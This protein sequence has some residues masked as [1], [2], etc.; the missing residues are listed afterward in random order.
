MK[1]LF[2]LHIP[3]T[4]GTYVAR[5][6]KVIF[7]IDDLNH[8][9]FVHKAENTPGYPPSPGYLYKMTYLLCLHPIEFVLLL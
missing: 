3:K 4:G 1:M 7:P 8:S 2:F 5:N 6:D 9:V